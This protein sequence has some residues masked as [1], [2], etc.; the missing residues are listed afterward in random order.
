VNALRQLGTGFLYALVSVVLV[1]GGLSLALAEGGLNANS[2]AATVQST[3]TVAAPTASPAA[4]QT[5]VPTWTV[6][7]T[8][9]V[10]SPT[11]G[12]SATLQLSTLTPTV[13]LPT[14]TTYY[15][16]PLPT[17]TRSAYHTS[18]ACGPYYGWVLAYYVQPGDTLYH[19]A[20]QYNTTANALQIANCKP[21]TVIF[22]GE[23]LWVPNVPTVTP[24]VTF[25]PVFPTETPVPTEPLTLTPIPYFTETAVPTDTAVP[26]P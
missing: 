11:A 10:S 26:N 2:P 5:E 13:G 19:I 18:V 1:V 12:P 9:P 20:T 21:T 23:R 4:T 8:S 6:T 3:T 25:V 22:V 14:A 7:P 24:G 17:Y 15:A 16:P